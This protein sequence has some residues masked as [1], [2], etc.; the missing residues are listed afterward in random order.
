MSYYHRIEDDPRYQQAQELLE[1]G[2]WYAKV[3]FIGLLATGII[4]IFG[5]NKWLALP[6]FI[7][8]CWLMLISV[9]IRDEAAKIIDTIPKR[10]DNNGDGSSTPEA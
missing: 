2:Y 5:A 1:T 4:L 6:A 3:G 10:G 7:I 8:A 9:G